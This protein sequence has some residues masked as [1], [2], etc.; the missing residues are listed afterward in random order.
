MQ[1][2]YQREFSNSGV[3]FAVGSVFG[4]RTWSWNGTTA[5][6]LQGHTGFGWPN[7]VAQAECGSYW[8]FRGADDACSGIAPDCSCG[9]YAFWSPVDSEHELTTGQVVGVIEAWGKVVMGTLGFRAEK[10]RIVG[11]APGAITWDAST[12]S[13]FYSTS[14]SGHGVFD[15][16]KVGLSGLRKEYPNL[17]V[18]NNPRD[19]LRAFP[20]S[21]PP[22]RIE[23]NNG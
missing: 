17:V 7:G 22:E 12:P 20:L 8:P 19:M 9:F 15:P 6:L 10:A 21:Q 13:I 14:I 5:H 23:S 16:Q 4:V 18:F 11:V 3:E 1:S 2:S